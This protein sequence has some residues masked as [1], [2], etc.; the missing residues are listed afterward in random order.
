MDDPTPNSS[1]P[2]TCS[3]RR[4]RTRALLS[5]SLH[6]K[7]YKACSRPD[8]IDWGFDGG[9]ARSLGEAQQAAARESR[10]ALAGGSAAGGEFD[11]DA[12]MVR[13]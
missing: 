1:Q 13:S 7:R 12:R 6:L 2:P 5:L 3:P 8:Y 4:F 10:T 11:G 9:A